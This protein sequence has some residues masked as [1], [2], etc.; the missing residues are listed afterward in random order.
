MKKKDNKIRI[1]KT[2]GSMLVEKFGNRFNF[3]FLVDPLRPSSF[4]YLWSKRDDRSGGSSTNDR[5]GRN[6]D[7]DDEDDVGQVVSRKRAAVYARIII[8]L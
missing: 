3:Q 4:Y 8:G 2:R 5:N 6:D 7:D 1:K